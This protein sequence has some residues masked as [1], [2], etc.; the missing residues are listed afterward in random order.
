M[1]QIHLT[2]AASKV[3]V[4]RFFSYC[5]SV[6]ADFGRVSAAIF[7]FQ[8]EKKI[9]LFSMWPIFFGEAATFGQDLGFDYCCGR[10][11]IFFFN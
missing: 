9:N 10:P 11:I 3:R 5:W 7:F 6:Q 2:E 8:N 4:K 1:A